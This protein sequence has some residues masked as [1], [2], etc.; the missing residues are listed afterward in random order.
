MHYPS[1][2]QLTVTPGAAYVASAFPQEYLTILFLLMKQVQRQT[3]SLLGF[4]WEVLAH[5]F[6]ISW[7]PL[8]SLSCGVSAVLKTV[9]AVTASNVREVQCS[10]QPP[11]C[12]R[13]IHYC[14]F[15]AS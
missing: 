6:F 4:S 15:S 14:N 2:E 12:G 11:G 10:Q 13:K 7:H 3:P 8:T 1:V 5:H 9:H